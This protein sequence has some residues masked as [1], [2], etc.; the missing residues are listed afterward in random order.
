MLVRIGHQRG[1]VSNKKI[2]HVVRLAVA[3]QH[4]GLRIRAHSRGPHLV[5][6]F[7]ARLNAEWIAPIDRSLRAVYPARCLDNRADGLLPVLSLPHLVTR[8]PEMEAQHR[9]A[10]LVDYDR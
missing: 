6:D 7:S 9:N 5:N 1:S 4:R 10:P 2:L 8:P 3:V